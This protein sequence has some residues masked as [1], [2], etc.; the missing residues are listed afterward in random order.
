MKRKI[1]SILAIALYTT[2]AQATDFITFKRNA[3]TDIELTGK[4]DTITYDP[5]DW[6]GVHIAV[7]NLR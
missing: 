3:T 5:N 6:K 7:R 2:M 4:A 1:V